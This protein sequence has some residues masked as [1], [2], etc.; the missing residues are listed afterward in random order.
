MMMVTISLGTLG[1][2]C[3]LLRRS[4]MGVLIG[5]QLVF[6]GTSTALVLAG[7]QAGAHEDGH[8]FGVFVL[9]TGLGTVIVGFALA[10]R[11]FYINRSVRMERL[12][13]LKH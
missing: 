10:V 2:I 6:L 12:G 1:I 13:M 9:L 3:L 4:V 7:I 8:L 5:I 11:L